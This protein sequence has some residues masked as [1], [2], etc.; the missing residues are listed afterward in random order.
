MKKN[1][2]E[3]ESYLAD[4]IMERPYGF[5]VG[6][7]HFFLYPVTLGKMYLL[8]RQMENLDINEK[9]L[10]MNVSLEVLRL[11]REKKDEC[12]TIICY[13]T[14]KTKDE[15]FD[16]MLM[17]ERKALFAKEMSDE[18]IAALMIIVL[19]TDRT[20]EVIRH[21]KIDKEKDKLRIISEVKEK[22]DKNSLTFGGNTIYGTF[23]Q[24]L[25]EMGLTYE[26]IVWQRSY[27]N[28]K[29]LLADKTASVY[30]SEEEMKKIPA[31][32]KTGTKTIKADDPKNKEI[33]KNSSWK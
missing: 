25:I 16:A 6:E 4:T 11:A 2:K 22:S 8:Q 19:T 21:F 18:D 15:V 23:I 7:Q 12:L 28:L 13:H 29:L 20:E 27:A 3:I 26:E 1:D 5:S 17:A 32:V 31:W 14:C 33:I 30:L 9:S 24:P 10:R